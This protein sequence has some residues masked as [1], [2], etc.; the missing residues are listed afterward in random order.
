MRRTAT[1]LLLLTATMVA[2][3]QKKNLQITDY[4]RFKSVS[5]ELSEKGNVVAFVYSTPRNDD[6]L[7]IR[8]LLSGRID[9]V[10]NANRPSI[11]DDEKWI[12]YRVNPSFKA[13]EKLREERKPVTWKAGLINLSTGAKTEI[14]DAFSTAFSK[15]SRWYAVQK[16][17]AD[18]TARTNGRD[19]LDRK[20]VV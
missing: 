2:T 7:F 10:T 18:A 15:G 9:T 8:N 19:L 20:S 16:N 4:G 14:T 17:K 13:A 3:A 5:A 6:T 1:I 12:S 11:S